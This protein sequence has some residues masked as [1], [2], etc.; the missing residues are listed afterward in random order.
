VSIVI[1]GLVFCF[2]LPLSCSGKVLA[3]LLEKNPH[4]RPHCTNFSG[5]VRLESYRMWA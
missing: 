2:H 5:F 4:D 1:R 3:A